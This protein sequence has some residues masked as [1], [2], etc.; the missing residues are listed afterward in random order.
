MLPDGA[1]Q[2]ANR[3]SGILQA[4]AI[5]T[6]ALVW[7]LYTRAEWKKEGKPSIRFPDLFRR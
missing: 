4:I 1:G 6:A 7:G 3:S 2:E 5:V